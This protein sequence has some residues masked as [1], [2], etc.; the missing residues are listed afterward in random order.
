MLLLAR[1]EFSRHDFIIWLVQLKHIR[2]GFG[3]VF[4]SAVRAFETVHAKSYFFYDL[5]L[6][7]PLFR[8]LPATV[9]AVDPSQ[10]VAGLGDMQAL[11]AL[12]ARGVKV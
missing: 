10:H 3:V 8:A 12:C 2:K 6:D 1:H 4:G 9:Y 11:A 7:S 5:L